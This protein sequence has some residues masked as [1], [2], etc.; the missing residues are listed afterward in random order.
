MTS[1]R[2]SISF[3]FFPTKTEAG[4]EKL[5]ATARR[6]AEYTPDFFS[7][8][9]G[10]GGS[11]RDRTL[12]TVLQLD[13]DVKVPTAPHLS[14]VGDSKQE[15]RELLNLYKNAGIKRIVALRGDLPSGMGMA[16]GELRYANEL[17]EFIRAE[18][19]DHFHIEIAAY[20]EMHPQARNFEADLANF[21]RKAKAGADSA[22]T[23]YFFNA[24]C[25][26]YFVERVRKL[27]VETPIV[28]GIMPITNY[29]KL[30]RF[31][32]ACGAEIP[33]WVRKQLESYGDDMESIQAFG[34]QVIS[35]MCEELLT[36]GAPG[37]HFYT[38]NQAEPSLAIWNNLKLAR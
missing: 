12:N 24:D 1:P 32:D 36:G 38:L 11:T 7:C 5:L 31:S 25:Y 10:A 4:H 9:Y 20:P 26:F 35:E 18:T 19:G 14:C 28:P 2:P 16:S 30:A 8:T 34:E 29:S 17:V 33:R 23:Q 37:L 21:V 6:L 13:G 15:L 27:G 22:I 3:E